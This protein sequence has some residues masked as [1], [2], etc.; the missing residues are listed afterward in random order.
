MSAQ[1]LKGSMLLSA[2]CFGLRRPFPEVIT[3]HLASASQGDRVGGRW[4][5]RRDRR[6]LFAA[7]AQVTLDRM[8]AMTVLIHRQ[9]A[10]PHHLAD[11]PARRDPPTAQ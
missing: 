5:S 3:G 4:A 11:A 10:R 8:R 6:L 2:E 9:P 1:R 7:T